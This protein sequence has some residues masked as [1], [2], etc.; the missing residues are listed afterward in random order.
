[1]KTELTTIATSLLIFASISAFSQKDSSGIYFTSDDYSKQKLAYAIN[2]KNEKHS[3]NT[4]LIFDSKD[5]IVKHKGVKYKHPKD[6]VYA[7]KYCDGSI[8]RLFNESEYP[9]INPGEKIMIYK[10]VSGPIYYFSKDAKSKIQKLTIQNIKE[11]F[12]NNHKF[13]DLVDL[14][15]RSDDELASYDEMHKVMKI[16]RVLSNSLE[17]K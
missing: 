11:A 7:V 16:N 1:M 12:P 4:D 17:T 14:Q 6:S 15:F 3:M 5:I 8:K 9:L 13:H 10:L 2:C